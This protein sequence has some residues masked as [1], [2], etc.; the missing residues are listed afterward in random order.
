MTRI[1]L[2]PGQGS[3][4]QGMG[5]GL[6]QKYPALIRQA[7]DIL[8]YSIEDICLNNPDNHL[9]ETQFTQP[10]LFIV[11]ALSFLA[12][13]EDGYQPDMALGHSLGEYNALLTADVFGFEDGLKIV[14]ERARLMSEQKNGG[15]AAIIGVTAA[16]VAELLGRFHI[17]EIDVA[18]YNSPSQTV[19]SGPKT[20][21][22]DFKVFFQ[23]SSKGKFI[24]LTVSGAFHSRFMKPA[25]EK[26]GAFLSGFTFQTPK[27][28][29]I[30]NVTA[31]LY[32]PQEIA[33]TLTQQ[34]TGSVRWTDS[35]RLAAQSPQ[36]EWTEIGPGNVLT[37][38]LKKILE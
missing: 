16:E 14:K 10:A 33:H 28:P 25:A 2:F 35:I 9:N 23:K 1:A 24:P 8:G 7:N 22:E 15:M 13:Q 38:L 4:K 19:I 11:N 27:L 5:E 29:V 37:N 31:A 20:A 18:N 12:K 21:I 30:A 32:T 34:L 36:P 17:N 26:F 6:F 3:Q